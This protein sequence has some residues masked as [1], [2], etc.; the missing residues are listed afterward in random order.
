MRL[1]V[2]MVARAAHS[3]CDASDSAP[4]RS[5]ATAE[6]ARRAGGTD[7]CGYIKLTLVSRPIG[8]WAAS[9]SSERVAFRQI[10]K[11][12][13]NRLRQQLIDEE[14]RKPVADMASVPR[15]GPTRARLK[16]RRYVVHTISI[17]YIGGFLAR[18]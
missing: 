13:G 6:T 15:A 2:A 8:L 17:S 3:P 5:G 11:K 18:L 14:T 7:A 12:T 1:E 4:D 9:S 16:V 10:N